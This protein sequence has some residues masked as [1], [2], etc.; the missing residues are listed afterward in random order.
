MVDGFELTFNFESNYPKFDY[1]LESI[2]ERIFDIDPFPVVSYQD[3]AMQL[4]TMLECYNLAT[5][6]DDEPHNTNIPESEGTREVQ[7]LELEILEITKKVKIKQI[8]IGTEADPKFA[9][10]GDY[11]DKETVGNIADLLRRNQDLFPTNLIEMKG[12]IGDLGVMRIPLKEGAKPVK[13]LPYRLNPLYK[14]KV[15]EELD[16]MIA[17]GIIETIEESEWIS[18]MVT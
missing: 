3:W 8:N 6:E 13:Q 1:V 12:I 7:G 11:W 2:K 14:E 4:E 16:K 17:T 10:I 5:D 18:P 15:K 9:S